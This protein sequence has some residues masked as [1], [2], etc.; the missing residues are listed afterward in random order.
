MLTV[1]QRDLL[2]LYCLEKGIQSESNITKQIQEYERIRQIVGKL[3][4][5]N[6]QEEK[7]T[8]TERM[9]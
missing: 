2:T 4:E 1:N 7:T 8:N 5:E 9:G 3:G 6:V